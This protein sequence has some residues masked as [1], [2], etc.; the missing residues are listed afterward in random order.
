MGMY[1]R[2]LGWIGN[3]LIVTRGDDIKNSKLDIWIH[4]ATYAY[5]VNMYRKFLLSRVQEMVYMRSDESAT[6]TL[7][8]ML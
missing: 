3:P 7:D 4:W 2:I 6:F 5:F 1:S 8:T